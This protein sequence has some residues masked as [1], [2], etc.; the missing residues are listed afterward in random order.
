MADDF[1]ADEMH[2]RLRPVPPADRMFS[3]DV[4]TP[5]LVGLMTAD[6]LA[7]EAHLASVTADLAVYRG[8]VQIGL[9]HIAILTAQLTKQNARLLDQTRQIR[10]LMA[11]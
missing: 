1:Y 8:L 6:V 11:R 10:E 4:S 3:F 7:L 5:D 9:D 2:W